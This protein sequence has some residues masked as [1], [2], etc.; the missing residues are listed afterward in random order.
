[1]TTSKR[2]AIREVDPPALDAMLTLENYGKTCPLQP[3]L[4]ELIKI[5]ASQ[6]NG[7]AY[8]LD[9]H[10][11]DA[12]KL[13]ESPRR[14]FAVSV[15]HESHLFSEEERTILQLTEEVT[16]ISED[17]VSDETYNKVLGIFGEKLTAQ[18]IML[19]VIINSW[20]RMSVSTRQ[21]FKP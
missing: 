12:L 4:K 7:C 21:I 2:K 17:G 19:I 9:M 6:I 18:I 14:I 15:W 13:G 3:K 8:C 20:N 16:K 5:R 11:E 10:T 1:M